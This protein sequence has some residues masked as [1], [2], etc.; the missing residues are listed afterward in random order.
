M[1]TYCTNVHPGATLADLLETFA[2][3]VP[4]VRAA[5]GLPAGADFPVGA[6]LSRRVVSELADA[7]RLAVL[8]DLL[9]DKGLSIV[10]VNAFPFGDFHA[11]AVKEQ[12]YRPDWT[13]PERLAYTL[14]AARILAALAPRGAADLSLS[15][16]PL[17]YKPWGGGAAAAAAGAGNL[18]RAALA[19]A[20]LAEETG[21]HIR[22]C[23]EPEPFGAVE[24]T[25]ETVAFFEG[26]LRPH[27]ARALRREGIPGGATEDIL[28][29]YLGVCFDTC[30]LLVRFE[31][32]TASWKRL[33]AAGVS[34]GKVQVSS[35][36]E[37]SGAGA[38]ALARF[39]EP[40]Y[41]HQVVA[42]APGGGLA[43]WEDIPAFLADPRRGACARVRVHFHVPLHWSGDGALAS[44]QADLARFLAFL[45]RSGALALLEIETYTWSVFPRGAPVDAEALVAGIAREFAWAERALAGA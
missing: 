11:P 14:E 13:D 41:L 21:R 33:A 1:L 23:L 4:A 3:A 17:S 34:V 42:E 38:A 24:S 31:D 6:W 16:V 8:A 15:T 29:A 26:I 39:D 18:A 28:S 22:L 32:L 45:G 7:R 36:L 40:R 10:T 25:D 44:T 27:G 2:A 35:A 43:A 19:L 5:R 37:A 20:R 12:V 30:H 9:A